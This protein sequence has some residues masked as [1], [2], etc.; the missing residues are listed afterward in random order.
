MYRLL[1]VVNMKLS[2]TSL[3]G[4]EAVMLCRGGRH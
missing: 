4:Y 3:W 2:M 1:R